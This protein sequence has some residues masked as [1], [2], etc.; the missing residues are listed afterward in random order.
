MAQAG[1]KDT[2][3]AADARRLDPPEFAARILVATRQ[4]V[5]F[6][7]DQ[8]AI[9]DQ[10]HL[11]RVVPDK[12]RSGPH[13]PQRRFEHAIVTASGLA[14]VGI[15]VG[16]ATGVFQWRPSALGPPVAV[17]SN[18]PAWQPCGLSPGGELVF[19][20]TAADKHDTANGLGDT[21]DLL[22]IRRE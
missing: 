20:V 11:V 16:P 14:R 2:L 8:N 19:A 13:N 6:G 3:S 22:V 7:V 15:H 10:C 4:R 9:Y 17:R 5:A 12:R 21:S 18:L 1:R